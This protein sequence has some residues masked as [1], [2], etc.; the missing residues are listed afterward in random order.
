VVKTW[1]LPGT[2]GG[3]ADEPGTP[4]FVPCGF[5][6]GVAY[7]EMIEGVRPKKRG[8]RSETPATPSD[9]NGSPGKGDL[10]PCVWIP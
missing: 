10:R 8:S 7:A 1:G 5:S 2:G 9:M 4:L 6:I 3:P